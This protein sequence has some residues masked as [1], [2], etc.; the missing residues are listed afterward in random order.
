M[1][2]QESPVPS[3]ARQRTS[4]AALLRRDEKLVQSLFEGWQKLLEEADGEVR[5]QVRNL[6]QQVQERSTSLLV[7]D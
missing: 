2:A 1:V 6:L 4:Y 5:Q 7:K 3:Q